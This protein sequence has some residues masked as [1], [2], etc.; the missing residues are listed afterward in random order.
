MAISDW[1]EGQDVE[2]VLWLVS[3]VERRTKDGKPFWEG[4]FRDASGVISAKLWDGQ[5]RQAGAVAALIPQLKPGGPVRVRGR[6]NAYLGSLEVVLKDAHAVPLEDVDPGLF[7]PR[8]ARPIEEMVAEFDAVTASVSDPDYRSLLESLRQD[9]EFFAGYS[10][11]PAATVMH[12]AWV[13]GLLEHSLALCR[14]ARAVAPFYPLVDEDLL[15]VGCILHDAGK[16]LEIS[17]RPGFEYTPEGKLFGHIYMGARLAEKYMDA[18]PD[19][20]QT[21][22]R[23]IL[24]LILSHQGDRSEGFGSP[25][26]PSSPEAILF[27]HLDNLDAKLQNCLSALKSAPPGRE[28]T[29]PRGNSMRRGYYAVRPEAGEALTM[30]EQESRLQEE[31]VVSG[32]PEDPGAPQRGLFGDGVD[33]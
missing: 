27:H 11:A 21:K 13:G 23:H 25:I 1:K 26:D 12:H 30:G 6:I 19:F 9:G 28:F 7:S 16:A 4:T 20:P 5:G 17:P 32:S 33:A 3:G 18:I 31:P 29:D 24:H 10:R 2:A 22:R 15:A 14:I 8:S